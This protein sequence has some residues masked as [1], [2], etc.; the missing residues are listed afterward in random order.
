MYVFPHLAGAERARAV[1]DVNQPRHRHLGRLDKVGARELDDT[2]G[3]AERR[4]YEYR[5]N[6]GR[7]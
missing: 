4:S 2:A 7:K 5:C 3:L 1:I 6:H